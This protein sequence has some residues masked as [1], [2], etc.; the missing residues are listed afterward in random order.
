[1]LAPMLDWNDL[2]MFAEVAR[3]GSLAAA[4]R[5]LAVHPTTV[6]RRLSAAEAALGAPLFLRSTHGL[7][8][9]PAGARLVSSLGPLVDVV[10]EVARRA[11]AREEYPVRIATTENGA[12]ILVTRAL[13]RMSAASIDVELLSGNRVLDLA[14][15]D[16]DLALRVVPPHGPGLIARQLGNVRY[17]LYA[18]SEYLAAA[19]PWRRGGAGH[20]VLMPSAE[21]ALG[22]EGSWLAEHAQAATVALRASS[23]VTLALAA[24]RGAGV[25]VLP[26]DLAAQHAHLTLLR[27]LPEIPGRALWLVRHRDTR[28]D[29]RVA[30]TAEIIGQVIREMFRK[31]AE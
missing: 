8:L 4:A 19:P 2:R 18:S 10:D 5:T 23:H 17:A 25:C 28:R 15:G 12:R 16:A 14:R 21:V 6:A 22:P 9:A 27:R 24:E 26:T 30:R 3:R 13:A 29:P 11:A 7:A 20:R 31:M 1:M